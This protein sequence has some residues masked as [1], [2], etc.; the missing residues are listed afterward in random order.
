MPVARHVPK[1]PP[2]KKGVH[3]L[4]GFAYVDRDG[5]GHLPLRKNGKLNPDHVRDAR[6]RWGQTHFDSS[7]AKAK[8]LSKIR[9]PRKR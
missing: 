4:S 7:S 8:A 1:A 3:E 5:K 6:A 2:R 9:R